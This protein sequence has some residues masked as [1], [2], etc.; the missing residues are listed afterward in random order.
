M[1]GW[2]GAMLFR[3]VYGPEII[4]IFNYLLEARKAVEQQDIYRNFIFAP[5]SSVSTQ[6]VDDALAFLCTI[7]L[8]QKSN[9]FYE[10]IPHVPLPPRLLILRQLTLISQGIIETKHSLDPLYMRILDEIFVKRNCLF[11]ENMH[12]EVNK[13]HCV[14]EVG[15]ISK[16]KIQSWKRVMA[17]FGVGVRVG[18]G[19]QCTYAP[20][21][22]QDILACCSIVETTLQSF[23]EE[24]VASFVPFATQTLD[25]SLAVT[26]PLQALAQRGIV[27]FI[28]RKDT[29][30]RAYF[31]DEQVQYI[32]WAGGLA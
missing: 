4:A 31:G 17:F 3:T 7:S 10:A 20:A 8:A 23:F 6:S 5:A 29:P 28:A 2:N 19:F 21:L 9:S 12:L 30:C 32:R 16:E 14:K 24:H 1:N 13:L 11:I 27:S 22:L 15:G 18:G 25:A 26:I